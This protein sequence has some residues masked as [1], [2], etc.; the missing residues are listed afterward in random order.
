MDLPDDIASDDY[1]KVNIYY[2]VIDSIISNMEYRFQN[3]PLAKAVNAFFK[4]D[5]ESTDEFIINYKNVL[6]IDCDSMKAEAI[7]LKNM[8]KN[9]SSEK[10]LNFDML[11]SK[12]DK[13]IYPNIYKLLQVAISLPR[14]SS[15]S[16]E[17]SFSA[18]RRIKTWLRSAMHQERFSNLAF[19]NIVNEIVKYQITSEEVLNIFCKK[20]EK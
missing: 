3:V 16:C 5:L 10:Q 4:F 7:E 19:L 11:K 8:F 9:I 13:N 2:P 6:Q 20:I 15:A 14:I 1:W 18:M 17:R 12:I